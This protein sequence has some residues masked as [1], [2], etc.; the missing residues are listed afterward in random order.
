MLKSNNLQKLC[1]LKVIDLCQN[2]AIDD[3]V[4]DIIRPYL[5][6]KYIM[7]RKAFILSFPNLNIKKIYDNFRSN[8]LT[9]PSL[10][11]FLVNL[12]INKC[13]H[14]GRD[15]MIRTW[16]RKD[17]L[18][19]I[20]YDIGLSMLTDLWDGWELRNQYFDSNISSPLD[21]LIKSK[22]YQKK[23]KKINDD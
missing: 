7:N 20:L 9:S 1:A 5:L 17:S 12:L 11:T 18:S 13:R 4:Y 23:L 21:K 14:N 2:Q 3:I 16:K 10:I 19:K 8:D 6:E 15:W 22:A